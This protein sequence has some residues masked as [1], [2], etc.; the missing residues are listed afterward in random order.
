M[1]DLS[2][3]PIRIL[4]LDDNALVRA[5]LRALLESNA[6]L[7]VVAE[8]GK[9]QAA[10]GLVEKERPE[11]ILFHEYLDHDDDSELLRKIMA[12]ENPPR[13]I[14]ISGAD[15]SQYH[16]KAVRNGA[17]GIVTAQNSPQ[18]LFKAIEKVHSGEVWLDRSL[19]ADYIVQ[20]SSPTMPSKM[21]QLA[22]KIALLS[23]REREIITLIG[24]GLK[25]QQIA[26]Q[27]F[28]SE[29]TVRHHLSSIFKK[30][31][32]S[33]RLELVI[34]AYQNGLAKLPE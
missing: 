8:A 28:I 7:N 12:V 20:E 11:I 23:T 29:V 9:N 16:L 33:D 10:L 17:M 4:L 25:N 24:E 5:G 22:R 26:D 18:I 32:A 2:V 3:T 6:G 13:I 21:M 15:D 14:L 1:Q 19:I 31:G 34:F 27:L 30:L